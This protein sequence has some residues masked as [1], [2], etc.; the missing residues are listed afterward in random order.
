MPKFEK[1][2]VSSIGNLT[3]NGNLDDPNITGNLTLPKIT[4]DKLKL[5]IKDTILSIKNNV[6]YINILNGKFQ[7]NVFDL[8]L[9]GQYKNNKAEIQ[10]AQISMPYLKIK[11][12][13]N[14]N[15]FN[16]AIDLQNIE[17]K[18]IKGNINAFEIYDTIFNSLNFKGNFKNNV[19]TIT[20]FSSDIFNG[21]I[22]GTGKYHLN[23]DFVNAGIILKNINVRLLSSNFKDISIAGSGTLN[24]IIDAN[25]KGFTYEEFIKNLDAYSKFTIEDG[26]LSQFAK[27]ERFLQAGNILSQ[28]ILKLTLNSAIS[29]IS[30]QN[31]GYF[32]AIEGKIKIK[33]S[34]ARIEHIK[35]Q[36]TNMSLY[37][38]GDINL[39][40]TYSNL[41]I[42]GKIPQ[43]TVNVLG[44]FGSFSTQKIVDKMSQEAKD[45][46]NSITKSPFE[47]M[48]S[49]YISK[50]ELEKIP[51][52][53]N[54]TNTI[55]TREFT[56]NIKGLIS[57][58]SSVQN[59]KWITKE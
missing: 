39:L 49:T 10:L 28:S 22:S 32:K 1:L 37:L 56:V 45:T 2:A 59:F 35:T 38:Q 51:S 20:N 40:T 48:F 47:K 29:A 27:L 26:E 42:L 52:L 31:T 24:A 55:Q 44:E 4:S 30:N 11:E 23:D 46:I 21:Q 53:Y 33:N 15:N 57:E 43:S 36:G 6:F 19:L 3:I 7:E 58:K 13:N 34:N 18:E 14:L 8:I 17:I 12:S 9:Q 54:Q 25:F 41:I 50:E 5:D 16:Q